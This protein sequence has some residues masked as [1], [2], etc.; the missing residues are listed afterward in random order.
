MY[1]PYLT[2]PSYMDSSYLSLPSYMDSSSPST[3]C[4]MD[5][6]YL[7]TPGY[8]HNGMFRACPHIE[9]HFDTGCF[10]THPTPGSNS[11][12]QTP[13]GNH[14]HIWNI[15]DLLKMKKLFLYVTSLYRAVYT[16]FAGHARQI[17]RKWKM[18]SC[19]KF[20]QMSNEEVKIS[21]K[22]NEKWHTLTGVC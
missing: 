18:G 15:Q 20:N 7:S 2:T 11:I 6:S 22:A 12:L 19:W 3:P 17:R 8:I 9:P 1:Y 16:K 13:V 4:Y 10:G 21:G 14:K 5:S